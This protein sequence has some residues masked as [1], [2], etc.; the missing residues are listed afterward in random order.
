MINSEIT[1]ANASDILD[2]TIDSIYDAPV[3]DDDGKVKLKYT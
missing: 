3:K 2:A 1:V